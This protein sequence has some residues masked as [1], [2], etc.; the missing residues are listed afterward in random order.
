MET[1]ASMQACFH[2]G[3]R[4]FIFEPA[5]HGAASAGGFYFV[6]GLS[7]VAAAFLNGGTVADDIV[8]TITEVGLV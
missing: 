1:S 4:C 2:F 5:C 8:L 6:S 3:K 7:V